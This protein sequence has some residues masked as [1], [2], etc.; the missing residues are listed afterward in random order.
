[1]RRATAVPKAIEEAIPCKA[2]E[3]ISMAADIENPATREEMAWSKTPNR[4]TFLLPLMSAILPD[5][6]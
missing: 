5:G 3:A 1:V 2:R 4:K 6:T